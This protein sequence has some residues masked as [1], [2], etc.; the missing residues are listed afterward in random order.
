[1]EMDFTQGSK[2]FNSIFQTY[3]VRTGGEKMVTE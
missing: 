1:M 3:L 2:E